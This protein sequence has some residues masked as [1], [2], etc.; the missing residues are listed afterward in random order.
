M[1]SSFEFSASILTH[2]SFGGID[3]SHHYNDTWMFDPAGMRWTELRCMGHIPSPRGG[4]A[5]TVLEDTMY[6]FGG[7][8]VDGKD[9]G[10]LRAFKIGWE[11]FSYM[12]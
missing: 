8:G 4:H 1:F 10:D 9:L 3:G 2:A 5:A 12:S 7:R 11:C 6:V